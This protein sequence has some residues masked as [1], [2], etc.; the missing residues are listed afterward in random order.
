MKK[1][2]IT[3]IVVS[4]IAAVAVIAGRV[5]MTPENPDKGFDAFYAHF[6]TLP[7]QERVSWGEDAFQSLGASINDPYYS[8]NNFVKQPHKRLLNELDFLIHKKSMEGKKQEV[9]SLF[10]GK[11]A[12]KTMTKILW[13]YQERSKGFLSEKDFDSITK[14][15]EELKEMVENL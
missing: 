15:L 2:I 9:I 8:L 10:F 13:V 1:T 14:E 5:L 11:T 3:I 6:E 4:V 7:A 12:R